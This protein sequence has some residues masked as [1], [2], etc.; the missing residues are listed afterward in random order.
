[1]LYI[2]AGVFGLVVGSF[3]NAYVWRLYIR[4]TQSEEDDNAARSDN[5]HSIINGRSMCTECEH[6]L[7]VKDLVPVASWIW[8]RGKCRYCKQPI[9]WQYPAV[10]IIT[11]VLFILSV[12]W[13]I[14]EP[15]SFWP[16]AQLLAWLAVTGLF[17]ALSVYD[18]RWYIL[19]NAML[20]PLL[21]LAVLLQVMAAASGAPVEE[22][23]VRPL[24]GGLGAFLFFYLLHLLGRGKWMGG[25]DVKM[26]FIL[27]LLVGGVSVVV[28][29]FIAF[30]TA[31]IVGT[32]LI[33]ADKRDRTGMVPFGPFLLLGFWVAFFFGKALADWYVD[34]ITV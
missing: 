7:G 28:G 5:P 34:L 23:L 26:V 1:M 20:G 3:L 24:V 14:P 11:A 19:P 6:T 25:G 13:W 10:E 31:A 22:W 8:L 33:L 17:I 12:W 2:F 21:V 29:L 16:A 15:D 4:E 32:G 18:I 27:G 30:I 9:S